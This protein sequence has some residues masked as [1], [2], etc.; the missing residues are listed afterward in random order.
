MPPLLLDDSTIVSL[1]HRDAVER[2]HPPH[3]FWLWR[4]FGAVAREQHS[5]RADQSGLKQVEFAMAVHLAFY[6][7]EACDLALGL[8][9]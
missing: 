9:V 5:F 4:D 2:G 1:T 7:L 6:E 8:A 3:Q